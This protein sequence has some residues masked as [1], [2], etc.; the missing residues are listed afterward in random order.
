MGRIDH[1]RSCLTEQARDLLTV[2]DRQHGGDDVWIGV[3]EQH[4][5]ETQLARAT[6]TVAGYLDH[7]EAA[8]VPEDRRFG[9]GYVRPDL[10]DAGGRRVDRLAQGSH[11]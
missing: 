4:G 11:A 5:F 9:I 7:V 8:Q 1:D 3:A 10:P 6:G 2:E